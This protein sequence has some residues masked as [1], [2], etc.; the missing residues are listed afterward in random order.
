LSAR[1]V[2]TVITAGSK[3][4]RFVELGARSLNRRLLII[5]LAV[6]TLAGFGFRVQGLSAEGLSEDEFNKLSAVADYRAHGLTAA[7][8]EHPL[9][10]KAL[11]TVSIVA[12]EKWNNL[13][14]TQPSSP[15]HIPAET[16]LRLPG[17]IFGTLT[18]LL[19]YLF[20][21][22]LF[23]S[24]VALIA[25]ALWVFDPSAISFNRIAKEDTFVLF[26]FLLA[27]VFWLRGQRFAEAGK[28]RPL[29]Y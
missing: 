21:A 25:A 8:S 5:T 27:N 17:T 13:I 28:E 9:L 16:A 19:L 26:F 22:E 23:G 6:L 10:M 24:E 14:S 4:E 3:P 1:T 7:N 29:Y 11:Q 12:A 2:E 15:L 18:T 20:A